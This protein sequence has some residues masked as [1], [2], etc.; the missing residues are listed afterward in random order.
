MLTLGMQAQRLRTFAC[1]RKDEVHER[2]VEIRHIGKPSLQRVIEDF[3]AAAKLQTSHTEAINKTLL[4][5][6]S[7][8]ITYERIGARAEKRG[9]QNSANADRNAAQAK[10]LRS[11]T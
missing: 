3:G 8:H 6:V 11:A 1:R 4:L 7:C 2:E 10:R 5:K 9:R